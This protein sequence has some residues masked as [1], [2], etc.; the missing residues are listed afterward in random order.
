MNSFKDNLDI[1]AT[2]VTDT[3][4]EASGKAEDTM[5]DTITRLT[6]LVRVVRGLG[7]A[8][9][10]GAI[11]LERRRG[12]GSEVAS[13]GAGLVIGAGL[14]VLFAPAA[15]KETRSDLG[16]RLGLNKL[17]RSLAKTESELETAVTHGTQA[18]KNE[19]QF[20]GQK[21]S[22]KLSHAAEVGKEALLGNHGEQGKN[23]LN[24]A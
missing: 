6:K 12:P 21:A 23:K 10:L 4:A 8:D 5:R 1:A 18:L 15:G 20:V 16:K 11:G 22:D 9:M 13:F 2:K 14:G 17:A 7:V 3:A 19:V 24:L